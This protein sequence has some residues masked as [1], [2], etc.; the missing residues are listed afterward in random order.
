[1]VRAQ[2]MGRSDGSLGAESAV[3]HRPR[4]QRTLYDHDRARSREDGGD[5]GSREGAVQD[6]DL[7]YAPRITRS[8]CVRLWTE[9]RMWCSPR[10]S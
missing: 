7:E 1:M 5:A 4:V 2:P 6:A 9:V 3:G 8:C 10:A